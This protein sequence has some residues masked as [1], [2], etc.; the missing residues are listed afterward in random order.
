MGIRFNLIIIICL[1]NGFSLFSQDYSIEYEHK[2]VGVFNPEWE[3]YQTLNPNKYEHITG[4]YR[5]GLSEI[6]IDAVEKGRIEIYDKR[7][8]KLSLDSLINK[9]IEFEK[10]LSGRILNKGEALRYFIPYISAFEFEEFVNYNFT[11]LRLEKKIKAYS[12]I[13]IRY[14]DFEGSEEDRVEMPLF[15]IFPEEEL[16]GEEFIIPDTILSLQVLKYPVKTPY[17]NSIFQK[18]KDRDRSIIRPDGSPFE[19]PKEIDK[20]F[21]EEFSFLFYNE[22]TNMEEFREATKDIYP[23]DIDYM[24]IAENWS[25]DLNSLAIRKKP[26][27]IIPLLETDRGFRQLGIRVEQ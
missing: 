3:F 8:R 11:T 1:I 23:E 6:I 4:Y 25:I 15:W 17:T 2:R 12:P 26:L 19:S 14:K 18:S 7:K 16:E 5:E 10:D 21:V 27:Y 20:V 9:L 22:E 24:R 13:I